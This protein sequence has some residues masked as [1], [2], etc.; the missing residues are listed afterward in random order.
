MTVYDFM[1]RMGDYERFYI[2]VR[3]KKVKYIEQVNIN[4]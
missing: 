2:D 4:L 1:C 3:G